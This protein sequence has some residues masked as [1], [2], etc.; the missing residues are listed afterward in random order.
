MNRN[1]KGVVPKSL[2]MEKSSMQPFRGLTIFK[3]GRC[4]L[5]L[6]MN[7]QEKRLSMWA[8]AALVCLLAACSCNSDSAQSDSSA[9]PIDPCSVLSPG[10]IKTAVGMPPKAAGKRENMGLVDKCGWSLSGGGDVYVTFFNPVGAAVLYTP[11][12]SSRRP[13]DKTYESITGL[14]DEAVYRD[15]SA[16]PVDISE[17]VEVV[18]GKRHFDVHYVDARPKASGPSKNTMVSL[19]GTVLAHAP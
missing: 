19:A 17:S 4:T 7:L 11:Q 5:S 6:T 3:V 13:G 12:V 15:D 1:V 2:A 8:G 16:P 9:P 14:G 18:K 10:D